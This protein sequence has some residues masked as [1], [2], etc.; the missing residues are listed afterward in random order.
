[1]TSQA[2]PT[3][4]EVAAQASTEILAMQLYRADYPER[5][6]DRWERLTVWKRDEYRLRAK[7]LVEEGLSR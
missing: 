5:G 2:L 4:E 3:P 1:M 7:A 6:A